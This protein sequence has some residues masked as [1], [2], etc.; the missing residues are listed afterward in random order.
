MKVRWKDFHS[1]LAAMRHNYR[2][3]ILRSLKKM[4][5]SEPLVHA[6]NSSHMNLDKPTVILGNPSLC[7]PKQFYDLYRNVMDRAK[8][9]LE[10]LNKAFFENVYENMREDTELLMIRGGKQALAAALITSHD[11][12]MTFLLAG[13]NYSK[14]EEFD[15]YFN[16]IYG[17]VSL[18]IQRGCTQLDLGQTAYWLKQCIGG[19]WIPVFFYIR[20]ERPIPQLLLKTFQPLLFP[21]LKLK[22]IRVFREGGQE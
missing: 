14:L 18:A 19:E 15:V 6:W 5:Q 4:G 7:P 16:L 11:R 2:R 13:L 22:P 20:S 9:K 3:H 17:I 1:Y 8:I 10:V 12:R 21:E